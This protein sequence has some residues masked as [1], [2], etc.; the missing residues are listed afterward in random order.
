MKVSELIGSRKEVF[1]LSQDTSVMD[2]A[3]YLREKQVRSVGILDSEGQLAGVV[4]QSDISDKVAAENRCPAWMKVSEIMTRELLTV[5][6]DMSFDDCLWAMEKNGVYHLLILDA[7]N[8]YRG[9][10]S[11]SDLLKVLAADHKGRADLLESYM[12]PQR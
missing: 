9:M 12:F 7:Q 1:F 4:S 2:A 10:L 8:Q 3:K 6:P 11:V 5:T